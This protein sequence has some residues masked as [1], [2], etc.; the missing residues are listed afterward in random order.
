MRRVLAQTA[1][2]GLVAYG[3]ALNYLVLSAPGI[4]Y[5]VSLPGAPV[6]WSEFGREAAALKREVKQAFGR[7]PLMIGLDT[8]NI[9]SVLAFYV[10]GDSDETAS[11]V[12]RGILGRGSLM[13]ERWYT[14]EPLRGRPAI[15]FA[16][17]RSQIVDPTLANH[18]ATLSDPIEREILKGGKPAGRFY[19]RIGHD[20]QG[21]GS[22]TASDRAAGMEKPPGTSARMPSPSVPS[23]AASNVDAHPN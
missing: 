23:H 4:G 11:S 12:G 16:F 8:Y 9:A 19:Y 2:I 14:A 3:L 15:M 21:A 6:A 17:K 18:F 22:P 13:Y 20:F 10:A 5:A 7:A 1:A